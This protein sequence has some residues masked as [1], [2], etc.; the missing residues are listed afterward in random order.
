MV[1]KWNYSTEQLLAD[2]DQDVADFR[3]VF[4]S[5]D[6]G[7]PK[8]LRQWFESHPYLKANDHALIAG[9]GLDT[10]GRWKRQAGLTTQKKSIPRPIQE[11]YVNTIKVP[12]NWATKEWLEHNITI[13]G[14]RQIARA[15]GC[16]RSKVRKLLRRFNIRIPKVRLRHA[17]RTENWLREYVIRRRWSLEKCAKEAGVSKQTI[18][19]WLTGFGIHVQASRECQTLVTVPHFDQ[20]LQ[21]GSQ[22]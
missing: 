21:D 3:Q 17:C 12:A 19:R 14:A 2:F 4:A 5:V 10:I 18:S 11:P 1:T 9:V 15:A 7:N 6:T 16:S 20:D 22:K 13:F 8:S